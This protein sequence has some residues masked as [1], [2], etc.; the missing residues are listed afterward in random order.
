MQVFILPAC[1]FFF[2]KK[3]IQVFLPLCIA[4]FWTC[5][6]LLLFWGMKNEINREVFNIVMKQSI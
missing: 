6:T 2:F 1:R 4:R 5:F 3:N